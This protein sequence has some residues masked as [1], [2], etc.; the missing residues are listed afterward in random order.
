[1][2]ATSIPSWIHRLHPLVKLAWLLWATVAVFAFDSPVLPVAVVGSALVLFRL[3]G[4]ALWRVPGMRLCLTVGAMLLLAQVAVVRQG[5][6]VL[7]PVTDAGLIAGVRAAGRL[8]AVILLS[9]L[10]VTTTEPFNLAYAMMKAGLPYRWGFALVTAMRLAPIFRLEA[11]H[12]YRAQLVRGVAYDARIPRRLWL[13]LRHLY[14]P[15][16]VSALRTAHSLSL[17]MEGRGFG[18]QPKRTCMHEVR[19]GSADRFAAVL[20]V[21]SL[22]TAVSLWLSD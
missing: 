21:L 8:L 11:H 17:S 20:L 6:P 16:V 3:A 1:M 4:F 12:V 15:L 13:V 22:A 14:F 19:T 9:T 2:K 10:F 7:G 18:L 5:E